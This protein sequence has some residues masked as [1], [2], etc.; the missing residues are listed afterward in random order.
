MTDKDAVTKELRKQRGKLTRAKKKGPQAVIDCCNAAMARFEI[1]GYPDQ[2]S[3][4]QR[5]QDDAKVEMRMAAR[6]IW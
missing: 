3:E 5:A 2:W 1:V 4:F 6:P